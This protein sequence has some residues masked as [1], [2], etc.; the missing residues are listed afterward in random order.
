MARER[1]IDVRQKPK[2]QIVVLQCAG[3]F[4]KGVRVEPKIINVSAVIES[5]EVVVEISLERNQ[6]RFKF[7]LQSNIR[8]FQVHLRVLLEPKGD[9][10]VGQP[11]GGVSVEFNVGSAGELSVELQTVVG[12]EVLVEK[13]LLANSWLGI[14]RAW[15]RRRRGSWF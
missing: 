15:S 13:T 1:V 11:G 7:G 14:S 2:V 9:L 10:V 5:F 4:P 8:G 12:G 3:G 6:I